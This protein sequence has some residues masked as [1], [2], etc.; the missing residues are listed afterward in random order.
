MTESCSNSEREGLPD[1]NETYYYAEQTELDMLRFSQ[2]GPEW[3]RLERSMSEGQLR[4]CS[5]ETKKERQG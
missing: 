4:S 5:L 3:I 2:W 1:C